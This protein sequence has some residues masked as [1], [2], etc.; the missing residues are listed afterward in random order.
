[1]CAD[2]IHELSSDPQGGIQRGHGFLKDGGNLRPPKPMQPRRR[3]SQEALTLP[4][5][6]S[7][8]GYASIGQQ[9]VDG[10]TEHGLPSPGFTRQANDLA[11]RDVHRHAVQQGPW[12]PIAM[13]LNDQIAD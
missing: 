9:A 10:R 12:T 5:D 3:C 11:L 7:R 8:N 4:D 6:L 1:M 2:D 13:A